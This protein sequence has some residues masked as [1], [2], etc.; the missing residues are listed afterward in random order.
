MMSGGGGSGGGGGGNPFAQLMQGFFGDS[1]KEYSD[2]GREYE[3]Y[4]N[5]GMEYQKP[6]YNAGQRGLKGYEDW[7]NS[8][9]DPTGF[10]NNIMGQYQQSP[11]AKFQMQQGQN[12]ANNAA[13][14]SGLMGSTP[15]MQASQDYARNITSQDQNQW[16]N[17]VLGVNTQYGGS[18]GNLMNSGQNAANSLSNMQQQLAGNMGAAAFGERQGRQKDFGNMMNGLFGGNVDPSQI[19]QLMAM[20]G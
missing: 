15:Y 10:I 13:S 5:R 3:K 20:L 7:S 1:G 18:Q 2:F 8:M 6:F 9:K 12:A 16:L 17:N 11:Y 19:M 14:A 4:M